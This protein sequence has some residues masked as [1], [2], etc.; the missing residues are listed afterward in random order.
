MKSL[1][2][3]AAMKKGLLAVV[4]NGFIAMAGTEVMMSTTESS[5]VLEIV[6]VI[7]ALIGTISTSYFSYLIV[8]NQKNKKKDEEA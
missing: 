8:I 1:V 2:I 4:F 6:K 5:E 7:C 3:L